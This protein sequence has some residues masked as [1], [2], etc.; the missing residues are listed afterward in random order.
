MTWFVIIAVVMIGLTTF[1]FIRQSLPRTVRKNETLLEQQVSSTGNNLIFLQEAQQ[2]LD[3]EFNR[4]LIDAEQYNINKTNLIKRVLEERHIDSSS[5]QKKNKYSLKLPLF[6]AGLFPIIVIIFYLQ[7]GTPEAIL[8]QDVQ[9]NN[10]QPSPAQIQDMVDKLAGKLKD[11]PNDKTGWLMLGR[12]YAALN[13]FQLAIDAL[14]TAL[15]LDPNNVDIIADL[16]DLI[17]FS[18]KNIQGEPTILITRALKIN[19]N[20]LKSLALAG[21][22]AF[23]KA[24]YSHAIELWEKALKQTESGSDLA[25]GLLSSIAEAKTNAGLNQKSTR[26][27]SIPATNKLSGVV[28]LASN[29]KDQ[30]SPEDT[31]FIYAKAT[32]GPKMPLAILKIQV[33]NLP[34]KFVLDDS[35][36]MSPEFSLSK[37]SQFDVVGRVSKSGNA[38]I[39]SGD[40]FGELKNISL[41]SSQLLI[42]INKTQP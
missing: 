13:Q 19:P 10:T 42:N 1:Y 36:S 40:F 14:K 26:P 37:F 7:I 5:V 27:A 24:D 4:G 34:Y 35:L 31:L 2:A 15:S 25:N 16:A 39:Q 12:S 20:H 21:S 17:A 8:N 18:Q 23:D 3:D 33:K 9:I 32:D 22:I 28:Q 11:N 29:L 38:V 41:G 30:V 6:I